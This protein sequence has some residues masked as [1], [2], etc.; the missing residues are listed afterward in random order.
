MLKCKKLVLL[1]VFALTLSGCASEPEDP[2]FVA[3]K[4]L[5]P[6]MQEDY[7]TYLAETQEWLLENRVFFT[8]DKQIELSAVAPFELVPQ[9]PNGQGILLVHGLGD[10]PFSYVDI[11]P[12][13]AAQ[14]Y[15][16]R[17]IL[18]PGHGTRAA[19]LSL[20]E[21][22]DW[23]NVVAHHYQLLN[24]KVDGVWLGG[25]STG[26]NLVTALAYQQP[27]VKGLLL[28]SPAFKPRNSLAKYS[29]YAKWFIDWEGK[30]KEDNYTRY[31]SLHMNG[32]ATYYET[33]AVVRDY[34]DD[35]S[36]DKPTFVMLSEADETID[37]QYAVEQFSQRFINSQNELLWFGETQYKDDRITSYSMD[38]PQQKILSASH[39]SLV[40]SPD[41]PIYKRDGEVRLCFRE[42]PEGMPEDCS[43]VASD[44]VWFA[45]F[46]DGEETQV[47]ARISWNPYF[48]QSMQKLNRF[49]AD[50]SN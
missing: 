19:D 7:Q 47:R 17:V 44:Q 32:A 46:G 3:S 48:D 4:S 13:L 25:F 39:I 15:L 18:L 27:T 6:Y 10:S 5:Q 2:Q 38:L 1:S 12:D 20:P 45:A 29:P 50:N 26:A 22:E 31:N 40:F 42:Q 49:L 30:T 43:E 41:N 23:Q 34:L 33:S 37:S 16:V 8:D 21:L 14:G 35:A 9:N 11:A 36:Y 24:A 28:F